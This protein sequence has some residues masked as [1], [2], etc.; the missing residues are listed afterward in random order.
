MA[1]LAFI[2]LNPAFLHLMLQCIRLPGAPATST[3]RCTWG[4]MDIR[5]ER[6]NR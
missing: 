3:S 5:Y 1:V 2:N 4:C 6:S